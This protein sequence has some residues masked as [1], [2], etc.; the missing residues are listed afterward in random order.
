MTKLTIDGRE[1]VFPEGTSLFDACREARGEALPHF[2][3]HPDLPVAGVCRLCQVEIEGMPKLTIAC[4]TTVREGMVVHTRSERVRTAARQI[5][6]M[7]LINHPVDCPICDQA[8]ECGLQDQYMVY[9]LYE[10]EVSKGDKVNKVK[11]QVIG[12]H[13]IL[14]K[15]RCVLCSRCVRFCDHITG[16][17]ELGVFNRGDRAEIGIAPGK[18]LNN[19]YSLNTVDICP[20]GA[21]TSRDFRF[22]KRVWLLRSTQSVCPGCATGCNI[23]VDH[24]AERIYRIKP[25]RNDEVNGPW[26]CDLGRLEYRAVH[27]ESRLASPLVQ[28]DGALREAAWAELDARLAEF[29]PGGLAL[30]SPGQTLEE[31]ALFARLGRVLCGEGRVLG[32]LAESGRGEGD[33]LLLAADRKPNRKSLEWLDLPEVTAADLVSRTAGSSGGVLVYG[34]DPVA[35]SPGFAEAASGRFLVYLGTHRNATAH[36]AQVVVPLRAWAEKD[37]IFVNAQGRFQLIR[38]AVAGPERTRED[39]RF[40]AGWLGRLT[41]AEQPAGLPEVRRMAAEQAP[42]LAGVDLND[43]GTAGVAPLPVGTG[44]DA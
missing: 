15:E 11:A 18:E 30:A 6:E 26:M 23:R 5:L 35:D 44:G 38:R 27:A 10:S 12:P 21:L 28:R 7:H 22:K 13:V 20:V 40:L 19:N 29:A 17:G 2:C 41:T 3:Y 43:L 39:W 1:L 31:L 24:E 9:G 16:T 33:E 34:G 32:C 25:R 36:A 4:N 42:A 14:D 37:G 8:G